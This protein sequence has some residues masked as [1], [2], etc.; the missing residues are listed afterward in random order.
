MG[1]DISVNVLAKAVRE[2]LKYSDFGVKHPEA[3]LKLITEDRHPDD[4]II[5]TRPGSYSGLHRVRAAYIAIKGLDQE[6]KVTDENR[7]IPESHKS[8]HLLNHS[9][10]EGWYL[11]DDFSEIFWYDQITIGSSV[12]LLSE[13]ED[14]ELERAK[15]PSAPYNWGHSWDQVYIAAVASV[16]CRQPIKFH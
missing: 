8:S 1:L 2:A 16:V 14:M 3:A 13:L 12:R 7:G 10:C 5:H 15:L 9:D 4:D 6:P 11:P